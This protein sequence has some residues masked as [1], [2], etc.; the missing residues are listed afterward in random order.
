VYISIIVALA[1]LTIIPTSAFASGPRLDTG[2]DATREEH[3]CWVD[4]YDSGFA[5]K[6]DCDRGR[7]CI[8][9]SDNYN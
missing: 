2:D 6:Y 1:L 3:D 9:H 4:G 8:D 7:E 5:G